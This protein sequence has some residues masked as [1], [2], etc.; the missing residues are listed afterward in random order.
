MEA[1]AKYAT[2]R[3]KEAIA[4]VWIRPGSGRM[5]VNG[6]NY[7]EYFNNRPTYLK[8]AFEPFEVIGMQGKFDVKAKVKGGGLTGQV[9]AIRLAIARALQEYNPEWRKP[10]KAAG[11]LT[12]DARCVERKHYHHRKAR[13]SPQWSKR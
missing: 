9:E 6:R 1:L 13:R 2:G 11:L 8:K 5:I 12:R 7:K 3:R 4:R 10:L